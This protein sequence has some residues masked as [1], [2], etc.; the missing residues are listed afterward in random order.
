MV[1]LAEAVSLTKFIVELDDY[2]PTILIPK[3]SNQADTVKNLLL[4]KDIYN[5][6]GGNKFLAKELKSICIKRIDELSLKTGDLLWP[7][8]V[9]LSGLK[10]S[11]DVFE[12]SEV[13]G[14]Q[15]SLRRL[16]LAIQK[17]Q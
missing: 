5:G 15:E 4:A 16:D 2:D 12:I 7:L 10:A 3:K 13:L 1:T 8:R 6:V 14:K 11:P 9:A 17:V